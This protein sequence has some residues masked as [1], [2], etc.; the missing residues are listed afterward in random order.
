VVFDYHTISVP[1]YDLMAPFFP[2]KEEEHKISQRPVLHVA[3]PERTPEATPAEANDPGF[4]WKQWDGPG[5][6]NQPWPQS[7]IKRGRGEPSQPGASSP[8]L[9]CL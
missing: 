6:H 3:T 1:C 8:A 2:T 5:W 9:I 7:D 4:D